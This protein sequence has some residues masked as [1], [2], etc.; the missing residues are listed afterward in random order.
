MSHVKKVTL[1]EVRGTLNPEAVEDAVR[2]IDD[3]RSQ[4]QQQQ[5]TPGQPYVHRA[6]A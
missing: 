3:P 5:S 1:A 2:D 4:A 6:R